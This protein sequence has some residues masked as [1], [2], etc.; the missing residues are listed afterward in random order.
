M[1]EE[2]QVTGSCLVVEGVFRTPAPGFACLVANAA[3]NAS[4]S[5]ISKGGNK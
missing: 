5:Q 2:V 3:T 4:M 1:I